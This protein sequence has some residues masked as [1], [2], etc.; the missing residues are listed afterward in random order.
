MKNKSKL[1]CWKIESNIL[2]AFFSLITE[3]LTTNMKLLHM[4]ITDGI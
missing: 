4:L 1:A 2:L 3:F